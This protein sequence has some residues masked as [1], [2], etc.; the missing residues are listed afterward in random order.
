M[1]RRAGA[2]HRDLLKAD[3]A[4]DPPFAARSASRRGS[5]ISTH[6]RS[7]DLPIPFRRSSWFKRTPPR[8]DDGALQGGCH[9]LGSRCL[10]SGPRAIPR[11]LR[12]L[13][14]AQLCG[15][16]GVAIDPSD[17]VQQTLLDAYR[18]R[19]RFRGRT[20]AERLAW[21]RRLLACNLVNA[22][23]PQGAPS[24]MRPGSD[25]WRRCWKPPRPGWEPCWRPINPPRAEGPGNRV[26]SS[27]SVDA[28]ARLPE[29]NRLAL[30]AAPLRGPT[31]LGDQHPAGTHP[32]GGRRPLE[33]RAWPNCVRSFPTNGSEP[34][35]SARRDRRG[36]SRTL[37]S[38]RRSRPTW[39]PKMPAIRPARR[40]RGERPRAERRPALPS[41]A[42][43]I[44]SAGW[45]NLCESR[46][47]RRGDG[48]PRPP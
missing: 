26:E 7:G 19:D 32:A 38:M 10:D 47:G 16:A 46:A 48:L 12:I 40:V 30:V 11:Y 13:A 22:M 20:E 18:D 45:R 33:A 6:V 21:L 25:R 2:G 15:P 3:G 8:R 29:P 5:P 14:E 17:I 27:G 23:R 42:G 34:H 31:S 39:R 41:F 37:G 36:R 28:L 1:P 24:G 9:G 44:A 43:T 35:D 4:D